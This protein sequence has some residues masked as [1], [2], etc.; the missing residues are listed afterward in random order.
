MKGN[1]I[2]NYYRTTGISKNNAN[3]TEVTDEL[4]GKSFSGTN[5][6]DWR[7]RGDKEITLLSFLE[8][9]SWNFYGNRIDFEP[10]QSYWIIDS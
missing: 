4:D 7:R 6:P 9:R 5:N 8:K 3:I 1:T 2:N 10:S